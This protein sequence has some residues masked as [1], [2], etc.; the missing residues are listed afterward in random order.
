MDVYVM[1][2]DGSARRRITQDAGIG[3]SPDGFAGPQWGPATSTPAVSETST[4]LVANYRF[5]HVT[6]SA[7][8]QRNVTSPLDPSKATVRYRY[9]WNGPEYPGDHECIVHVYDQSGEEIG[10]LSGQWS[11]LSPEGP[12]K[13]FEIGVPVQGVPATAGFTC[14][15]HRDDSPVAYQISDVEVTGPVV[16]GDGETAVAVHYMVGSPVQ[17]PR[18]PSDNACRATLLGPSQNVVDSHRYTLS[19]PPGEQHPLHFEAR[20]W[21]DPSLARH[22]GELSATIDCHPFTAADVAKGG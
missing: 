15:P 12:S 6:V 21:P 8:Y 19:T 13:A 9:G 18:Y 3:F 22:P 5:S 1:A 17:L 7:G 4:A 16:L 2:S 10:S 11:S 20:R 14:S